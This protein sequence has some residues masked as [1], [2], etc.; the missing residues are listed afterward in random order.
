VLHTG[1]FH[2]FALYGLHNECKTNL[3]LLRQKPRHW[4][5]GRLYCWINDC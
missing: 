5:H 4:L 2:F 3:C 1:I